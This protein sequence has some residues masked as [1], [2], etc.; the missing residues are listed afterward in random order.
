M[1]G[2]RGILSRFRVVAPPGRA[3]SAAVPADWRSMQR[4]ELAPVFAALAQTHGEAAGLVSAARARAA[5]DLADAERRAAA[6]VSDAESSRESVRASAFAAARVGTDAEIAARLAAGQ[7]EAA[8]V[9][10]C[11]T[12]RRPEFADRAVAAAMAL[13]GQDL[14]G[15]ERVP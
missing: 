9:A 13:I 5:A 7:R 3:A 2:W 14:A 1:P 6:L 10:Q 4:D 11:A 15:P 8:R 12:A